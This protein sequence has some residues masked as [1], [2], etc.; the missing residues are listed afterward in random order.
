MDTVY[1]P[2]QL[3]ASAL[4]LPIDEAVYF[5]MVLYSLAFALVMPSIHNPSLRMAY[6]LIVGICL[7]IYF[8][9]KECA[10][11]FPT[12]FIGWLCMTLLP[13]ENQHYYAIIAIFTVSSGVRAYK[14]YMHDETFGVGEILMNMA[15]K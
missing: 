4:A 6:A 7:Q 11:T 10:I 14:E 12:A 9:H 2:A 13:R 3:V 8:I 1:V 5:T 15:A